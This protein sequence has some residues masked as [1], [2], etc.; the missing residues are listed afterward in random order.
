MTDACFK[1][2]KKEDGNTSG[3]CCCNC[4]WQRPIVKHPWNKNP[5]A[6]GSITTIMGYGCSV[7]DMPGI[8]FFE[9]EHSMCEMYSD[10]NNVIKME[11]AK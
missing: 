11:R 10:K 4:K 1:G 7:P 2:W 3:S 6:K 9:S 5:M 8:V